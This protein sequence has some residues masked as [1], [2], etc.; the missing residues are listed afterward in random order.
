METADPSLC[1]HHEDQFQRE[2]ETP[3][4]T[5]G[6]APGD[7]FI[8]KDG[9]RRTMKKVLLPRHPHRADEVRLYGKVW[10]TMLI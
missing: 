6:P 1:V 3:S 5:A 8:I 4:F 10:P 2:H 9:F 7:D